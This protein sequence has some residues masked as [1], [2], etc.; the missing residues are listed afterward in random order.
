MIL[1]QA[2]SN[3]SLDRAKAVRETTKASLRELQDQN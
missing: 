2:E 3:Q 1:K